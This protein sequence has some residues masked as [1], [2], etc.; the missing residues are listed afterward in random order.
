MIRYCLFDAFGTLVVPRRAAY[1]QYVRAPLKSPFN[2][3]NPLTRSRQAELARSYGLMVDDENVKFGFQRGTVART[4]LSP[5]IGL[6]VCLA[7][8]TRVNFNYACSVQA[9]SGTPSIVWK[10]L[11]TASGSYPVVVSAHRTLLRGSRGRRL[12]QGLRHTQDP[13]SYSQHFF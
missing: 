6:L 12:R 9:P 11:Y 5:L 13:T 1:I 3:V 4:S 10:T 8:R 2:N 7:D